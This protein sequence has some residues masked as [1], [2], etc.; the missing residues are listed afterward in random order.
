MIKT[1]RKFIT[2]SAVTI[3][4]LSIGGTNT[5]AQDYDEDGAQFEQPPVADVMVAGEF[6][7]FTAHA[8]FERAVVRISGP[9]GYSAIVRV[10]GGA[11]IITVDL[12]LDAEPAE[13]GDTFSLASGTQG[14]WHTLPAGEYRYEI[15]LIS[16][17]RLIGREIG[18]FRVE[19][20]IASDGD[21]LSQHGPEAQSLLQRFVG[22][23]FDLLIPSASAQSVQSDDWIFIHDESNDNRS[24][25]AYDN[26]SESSTWRVGH[27]DGDFWWNKGGF[28]GTGTTSNVM[29]LRDNGFLGLGTTNP[30]SQ[31]HLVTTSNRS[32]L[33]MENS[34]AD[35][36]LFTGINGIEIRQE[37]GNRIPFRIHRGAPSNSLHITSAGNVGLGTGINA[38]AALHVRRTDGTAEILLEETQASAT[39]TM[40]TMRH[41]GNPGFRMNNT[42]SGAEW[43]F[44]LG[45]SGST[46]Q[47]TI[48]KTTNAGPELSVLQNGNIRIKGNYLNGS[49]R[50]I[51]HGIRELDG[52]KVLD[53]LDTL[54]INEWR[55]N[56]SPEHVHAGPMAE[57]FYEVFGLGVDE[58]SLAL[59]DIPG[60][61]LAA[62]KELNA[63]NAHLQGEKAELKERVA[64]LEA[65][66]LAGTPVVQR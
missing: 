66:I 13:S 39:N 38:F 19:G 21:R 37:P 44:R 6:I 28:T 40:F 31:L 15:D 9:E 16:D 56:A 42:S 26:D 50:A 60:I 11:S 33:R 18:R 55:Y 61:A 63:R 23:V 35:Y 29:V 7:D 36:Q 52:A 34:N 30:S 64:R 54:T 43:D 1:K 53:Q 3:L 57:D 8:K 51:K 46:E 48:N 32:S 59:T 22:A 2:M 49:S 10:P 27:R 5:I 25:V 4:A 62:V 47:F 65:L 14:N 45:G 24:W 20:G 17:N 12:L 58:T 41:N